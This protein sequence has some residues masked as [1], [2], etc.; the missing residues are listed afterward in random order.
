MEASQYR[1][2][3]TIYNYTFIYFFLNFCEERVVQRFES[4]LCCTDQ[5]ISEFRNSDVTRF[6]RSIHDNLQIHDLGPFNVCIANVIYHL[7]S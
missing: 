5:T 2:L 6:L 1:P 3:K 4:M 7:S